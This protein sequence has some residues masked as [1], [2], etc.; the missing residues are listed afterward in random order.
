MAES[1][2]VACS[3]A[4]G[5]SGL[6][7]SGGS[8]KGVSRGCF[9]GAYRGCFKGVYRLRVEGFRVFLVNASFH[10]QVESTSGQTCV[11]RDVV[12]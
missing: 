8:F 10:S 1:A 4:S 5:C 6:F 12:H 3:S 9:K 7:F 11:V 2:A